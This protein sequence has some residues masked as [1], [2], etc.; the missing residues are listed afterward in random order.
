MHDFFSYFDLYHVYHLTLDI[1][2]HFTYVPIGLPASRL[3][4]NRAQSPFRA[5]LGHYN[6]QL[7][8]AW[9]IFTYSLTIRFE[10]WHIWGSH[11]YTS[12][13]SPL[14]RATI[15]FPQSLERRFWRYFSLQLPLLYFSF[16]L[17]CKIQEC[18]W[19]IFGEHPPRCINIFCSN[20][21]RIIFYEQIL[22]IQR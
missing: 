21:Q 5:S 1:A 10:I 14:I 7:L 2:Y 9:T 17:I 15:F 18:V 19:K 12:S 8:K 6:V 4:I 13:F 22:N 3:K 20:F 16:K 11:I